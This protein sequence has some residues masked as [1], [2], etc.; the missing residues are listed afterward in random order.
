ML[1]E[2]EE[3]EKYLKL[4]QADYEALLKDRDRATAINGGCLIN[5][6]LDILFTV[7]MVNDPPIVKDVLDGGGHGPLSSFAAKTKVAY[8]LSLI[9][10]ETMEDLDR[11]RKIRNEFA[12]SVKTV[13]FKDSPVREYCKE[14]STAKRNK[15]KTQDLTAIYNQAVNENIDRIK[16][17]TGQELSR[18]W[19]LRK[20]KPKAT[21]NQRLH[22]LR[23]TPRRP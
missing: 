21:Q 18:R 4:G 10:E 5:L 20:K 19:K 12:H 6:Y 23:H 3:S 15:G 16:Q 14:L 22:I 8:A 1:M 7:V 11:I 13:S 2:L 17:R 9:D